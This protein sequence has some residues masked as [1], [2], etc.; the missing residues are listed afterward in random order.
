MLSLQHCRKV[1]GTD[2]DG[3]DEELANLREQLYT[4]AMTT[5]DSWLEKRVAGSDRGFFQ[6]ATRLLPADQIETV[7]ERAALIEFDGNYERDEAERLAI[8]SVLEM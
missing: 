7:E 5:A 4:L 1:L 3:S 6:S 8:E 2:F